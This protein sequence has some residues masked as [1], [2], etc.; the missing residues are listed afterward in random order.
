MPSFKFQARDPGGA[1]H[2]GVLDAPSPMIVVQNLRRRGWRVVDVKLAE[3]EQTLSQSLAQW[4]P[5]NLLPPRSVHVELSCS[6]MTVML[7]GGL[8]LLTAL[9]AVAEHAGSARLRETWRQCAARIQGGSSFAE[10]LEEA[11]CFPQLLVRLVHVGEQT[12]NLDRSLARA[13]EAMES[14]RRLRSTLIYA[15]AYP[16]IVF[17]AAMGVTIFLVVDV[18]PKLKVFLAAMGRKLP[19]MTQMLVDISDWFQKYLG[20]LALSGLALIILL[21]VVYSRPRG[22]LAI[23]RF[24]LRVPLIGNLIRL[25]GTA[26][27]AR[28]LGILIRSGITILEGLRTVEGLIHNRYL[29]NRVAAARLAVIQGS[30]LAEPLAAKRAF[31][32]LLA[33]MVAVG[34]SSGTMDDVLD[35]VAAFHESQ[36]QAAIRQLSLIIEPAIILSVGVIVGFVYIA[37]FMALFSAGGAG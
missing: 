27:F 2:A 19:A 26:A 22:R 28:T 34:E 4:N 23:D 13:A 18:I 36:L 17:V 8:T 3:A 7:R 33:R 5:I 24:L 11:D 21:I 25:A 15:L 31:T 9:Q 37:F 35:E 10:A 16:L 12:G 1:P 32:P 29:T 6:Q 30:T 14:R 20:Y